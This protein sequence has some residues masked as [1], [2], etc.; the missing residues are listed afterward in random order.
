MTYKTLHRNL[1]IE[2]HEPHSKPRVNSGVPLVAHVVLLLILTQ[3]QVMND[4]GTEL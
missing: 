1:K 4:E 3:W 2:Q